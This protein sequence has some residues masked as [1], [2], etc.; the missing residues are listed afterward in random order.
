MLEFELSSISAY[1]ADY[2]WR[3]QT[4]LT[5]RRLGDMF[6]AQVVDCKCVKHDSLFFW[7]HENGKAELSQGLC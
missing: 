6:T 7:D 4:R 5:L 3:D 1:L 2:V